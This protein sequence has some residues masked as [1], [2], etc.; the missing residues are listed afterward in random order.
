MNA[1][2]RSMAWLLAVALVALP[3]VA[4]LNGWVGAER[5]PL[6]RLRASGEFERVQAE[7]LQQAVAPYAARGFF[8]VDLDAAQRA[9]EQLPWVE[10]ARVRKQWPD[11]LDIHV[12][13]HEPFAFWGTDQLLSARGRLF[14]LPPDLAAERMP[15]LDGPD[16]RSAEV[17]EMY[18]Q[19]RELFAPLGYGVERLAMDA[20]GS[21]SLTLDDGMEVVIGRDDARARLQRFARMLPTLLAG[22]ARA[23]TRADLRYTNGFTLA[24]G[25]PGDRSAPSPTTPQPP[26][27]A[28]RT[29]PSQASST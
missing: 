5:W 19:A 2:L 12:E 23:V 14:P 27:G 7:Q 16:A 18:Q 4:V 24:W 28:A 20:R 25:T 17:V 29:Q 15:R 6:S 13:E 11:A 9:V 3:V 26:Q 1:L 21:W 22:Q 10:H 8:A